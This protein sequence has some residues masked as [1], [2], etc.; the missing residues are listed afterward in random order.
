MGYTFDAIRMA[1]A[2]VG[3]HVRNASVQRELARAAKN[4]ATAG[5]VET[6]LQF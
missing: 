6:D 4:S 1:L 2:A 5:S 3:V